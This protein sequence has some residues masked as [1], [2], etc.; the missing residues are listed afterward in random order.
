LRAACPSFWMMI[1]N[2]SPKSS[3]SETTMT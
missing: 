1:W 3:K 2:G